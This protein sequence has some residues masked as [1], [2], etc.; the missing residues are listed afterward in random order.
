MGQPDDTRAAR[1][2]SGTTR[3]RPEEARPDAERAA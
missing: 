1:E 3:A 2:S